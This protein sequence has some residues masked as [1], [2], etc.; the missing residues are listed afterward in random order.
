MQLAFT[1]SNWSQADRSY[2]LSVDIVTSNRQEV[3]HYKLQLGRARRREHVGSSDYLLNNLYGHA[4]NHC[5]T[6]LLI[7]VTK[8][9]VIW[10]TDP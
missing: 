6:W 4:V 7:K 3:D 10:Y 5:A 9:R 1:E 2:S 8:C